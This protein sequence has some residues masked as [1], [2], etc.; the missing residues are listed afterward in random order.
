[1]SV[2]SDEPRTTALLSAA[3]ELDFRPNG[4]YGKLRELF[5]S[6]AEMILFF[7]RVFVWMPRAVRFYPSE[8]FRQCGILILS[9]GLIICFME[10]LMG[11]ILGVTGHYIA[12]Q[13]G[14]AGYVGIYPAVGGLRV[15]G[16]EMWG[17]I[18][19]AKVGCGFVAELGSMRISEEIDALKVMGIEPMSYL[20]GTR[21][22]AATIAMPFLYTI[23]IGLLYLGSWFMTVQVLDTVSPGGFSQVLWVFQS[24]LDLFFSMSWTVV[25]GILVVLVGCYYG[26]TAKG[27]PV[28]VG[29]NTSQSMVI[30]MVLVSLV[31][32][33]FHQMFWGDFANAPVAN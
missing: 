12:R 31:G 8:V 30:N 25:M 9:S 20:V 18:L 24:P 22:L 27:G 26:Y 17:W 13:F 11:A 10:L 23:G 3:P 28:G 19:A 32:L 4:M 15:G 5:E 14:A 2:S 7:V 6:A 1:M 16:P 33:I 21:V 29:M